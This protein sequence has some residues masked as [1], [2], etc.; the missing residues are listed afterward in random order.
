MGR[1]A[2]LGTSLREQHASATTDMMSIVNYYGQ[3]RLVVFG[4]HIQ[5]QHRANTWDDG[6]SDEWPCATEVA[7]SGQC[8]LPKGDF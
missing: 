8:D 4:G 7:R 3:G 5:R 1:E 2:R 6:V